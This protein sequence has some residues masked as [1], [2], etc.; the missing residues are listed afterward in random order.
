MLQTKPFSHFI[1]YNILPSNLIDS[2]CEFGYSIYNNQKLHVQN[3]NPI[4]KNDH[5]KENIN[6]YKLCRKFCFKH[7][8]TT[9]R[10]LKQNMTE[11]P[12]RNFNVGDD[13]IY[14][15]PSV[16]ILEPQAIYEP[17][18][19]DADWKLMSS[20]FYISDNGTGTLLYDNNKQFYEEISWQKGKGFSFIP[21][22]SSWHNYKNNTEGLRMA[23]VINMTNRKI[24]PNQY[25]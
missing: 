4:M 22:E 24:L 16:S 19:C 9:Y 17:I 1:H 18:H 8:I 11:V 12:K 23:L 13:K 5:Y 10:L 2:F 15:I 14:F 7:L 3:I 21:S 25:K 20:I 6:L